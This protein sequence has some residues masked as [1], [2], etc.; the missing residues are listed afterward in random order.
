MFV[1]ARRTEGALNRG[2]RRVNLQQTSTFFVA[3]GG[4]RRGRFLTYH[5]LGA[6]RDVRG[7]RR[8]AEISNY[9]HREGL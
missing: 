1:A 3:V 4:D 5:S 7:N 2:T 6:G 8:I 9:S